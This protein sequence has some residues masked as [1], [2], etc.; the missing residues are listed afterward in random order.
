VTHDKIKDAAR[1]RVAETG[2]S[3]A[4][5]RR[6]VIREHQAGR[7]EIPRSDTRW[8]EI[9]YSQTGIDRISAWM[10]TLLGRGPGKSGVQVGPDEIRVRMGA[11]KFDVPRGSVR[12]ASRSGEKLHGTTGVH[13]RKKD[14]LLVNGSAAGLVEVAIDPHCHTD[15]ALSTLFIRSQVDSLLV[16]L[17]DPDGFIAAINQHAE[18]QRNGDRNLGSCS[19]LWD[20]RLRAAVSCRR[21]PSDRAGTR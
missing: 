21:D 2:E 13:M 17:V 11:Y 6:E 9:S 7:D 1:K 16:S 15:R 20:A 10:D 4:A 5:A 18:I 3:Y 19:G 12:S 14:Q 8:F